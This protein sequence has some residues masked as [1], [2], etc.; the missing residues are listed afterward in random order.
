MIL[1]NRTF[2]L[3]IKMYIPPKG[4]RWYFFFYS[5]EWYL[6]C[7]KLTELSHLS[8]GSE[9]FSAYDTVKDIFLFRKKYKCIYSPKIKTY[10][11]C[12]VSI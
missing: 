4:Q 9:S 5:Q 2:I 10:L 11:I 7:R 8:C 12:L 1:D 3:T 6:R